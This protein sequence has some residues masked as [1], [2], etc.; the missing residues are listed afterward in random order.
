M[1]VGW[2]EFKS[3]VQNVTD[4]LPQARWIAPHGATLEAFMQMEVF[5]PCERTKSIR[6]ERDY[7]FQLNLLKLQFQLPAFNPAKIENIFNQ[8][9]LE[10]RALFDGFQRALGLIVI[11][12][13]R[14][15]H[16]AP[17]ENGVDRR[18]QVMGNLRKNFAGLE[19]FGVAFGISLDM[20]EH[21]LGP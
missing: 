17:Q 4:D 7:R 14:L 13:S 10:F 9:R 6:C 19:V 16:L 12:F 5:F 1:P 8:V 2:C 15:Q 3:I 21:M 11:Q 20:I 18:S